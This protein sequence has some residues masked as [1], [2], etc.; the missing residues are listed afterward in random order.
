M[1]QKIDFKKVRRARLSANTPGIYEFKNREDEMINFIQN[2]ALKDQAKH[3]GTTWTWTYEDSVL[4]G[5][6]SL[7]M[8]SIDRREIP[9]DKQGKYPCTTIPSLLIGQLATLQAEITTLQS[10]NS[11]LQNR[12]DT[13]PTQ[14]RINELEKENMELKQIIFNLKSQLKSIMA[15]LNNFEG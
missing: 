12:L 2:E 9:Q 5:F 13:T 10:E 15:F 6:V 11:N 7:A 14:S 8:F 4:V 1:Q 3:V